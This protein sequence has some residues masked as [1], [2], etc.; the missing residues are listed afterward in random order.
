MR[1]SRSHLKCG[2]LSPPMPKVQMASPSVQPFFLQL[3]AQHPYTLQQADLS[4]VKV[5]PSHRGSG[6]HLT[7]FLGS[8]RDHNP[9]SIPIG[10]AVYAQLMEKYPYTSQWADT[11]PIKI[12]ASHGNIWLHLTHG[13]ISPPEHKKQHLDQFSRFC[14]AHNCDRQT[15]RQ[16][17][18]T[19]RS[20]TIGHI[21]I[22]STAM[23]PKKS[24]REILQSNN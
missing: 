10:S 14:T 12:A 24:Q 11:S 3:T 17:D 20:V 23:Q 18:H 2:S 6:P 9:N 19:A 5:A 4:P 13:S 22:C 21:Y 15:D 7:R 16:T 8:I 1:Q